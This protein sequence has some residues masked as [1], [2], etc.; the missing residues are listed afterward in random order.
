MAATK[1][2]KKELPMENASVQST[3]DLKV[4]LKDRQKGVKKDS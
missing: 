4:D 3:E 1:V 2:E